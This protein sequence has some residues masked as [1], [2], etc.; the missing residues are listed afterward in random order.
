M[1]KIE[2]QISEDGKTIRLEDQQAGKG[3]VWTKKKGS[4]SEARIAELISKRMNE[5]HPDLT[6][7]IA[8]ENE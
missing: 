2:F 4:F 5:L 3:T 1:L 6:E 8:E 7:E